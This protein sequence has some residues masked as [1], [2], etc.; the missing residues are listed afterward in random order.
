MVSAYM[1]M[2]YHF[3]NI[4][5]GVVDSR[6]VIYYVAIIL[7]YVFISIRAVSKAAAGRKGGKP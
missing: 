5:R 7:F 3:Q 1:G 6:D 4:S 2:G